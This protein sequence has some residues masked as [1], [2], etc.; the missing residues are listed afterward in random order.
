KADILSDLKL[1]NYLVKA[2][3]INETLKSNLIPPPIKLE[4]D[5]WMCRYCDVSNLCYTLLYKGIKTLSEV[6]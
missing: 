3:A 4:E 2:M 6:K 1:K 5:K